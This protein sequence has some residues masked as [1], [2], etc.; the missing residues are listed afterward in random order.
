MSVSRAGQ[1]L[2]KSNENDCWSMDNHNFGVDLNIFLFGKLPDTVDGQQKVESWNKAKQS[3][4]QN[5]Y[6]NHF[7]VLIDEPKVVRNSQ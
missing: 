4:D 7:I 5:A 6:F 3:Q 2:D 1:T